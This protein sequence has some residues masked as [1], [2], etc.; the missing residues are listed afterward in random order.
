M[1]DDAFEQVDV[2]DL[3]AAGSSARSEMEARRRERYTKMVQDPEYVLNLRAAAKDY[4]EVARLV[5]GDLVQW[6]RFMRNRKYPDY[7]SP[8]VVMGDAPK[9]EVGP[10]FTLGSD[11]DPVDVLI[12]YLDGDMSFMIVA[13]DSHR[14]QRI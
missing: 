9:P 10:L 7:G 5:E 8:C 6:K 11:H 2:A 12:G 3:V 4:A 13:V 1:S 14:L